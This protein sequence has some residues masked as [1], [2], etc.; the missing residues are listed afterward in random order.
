MRGN[1]TADVAVLSVK[2][3]RTIRRLHPRH[4]GGEGFR[5]SSWAYIYKTYSTLLEALHCTLRQPTI[6]HLSRHG[7]VRPRVLRKSSETRFIVLQRSYLL[8]NCP[9]RSSIP[10]KMAPR[11]LS[12]TARVS[13]LPH[14]P[15]H[16]PELPAYKQMLS[17]ELVQLFKDLLKAAQAVQ[18]APASTG[19]NQS[20]NNEE[21]FDDKEKPRARASKLDFRTVNEMC[22]P[23]KVQV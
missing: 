5:L 13:T 7:L 23:C 11:G 3:E 9:P 21:M 16:S 2:R 6:L 1:G 10:E 12:P 8:H 4:S 22:V 14:S 20:A 17:S 18:T 19:A 15:P